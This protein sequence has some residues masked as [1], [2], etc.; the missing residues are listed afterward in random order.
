[1]MMKVVKTFPPV[2]KK[3]VIKLNN[4]TLLISGPVNWKSLARIIN[5]LLPNSISD[6]TSV[7][8]DPLNNFASVGLFIKI[9]NILPQYSFQV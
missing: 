3:Q 6:Y 1:M 8:G 9:S 2:K 7:S 4:L 5:Y